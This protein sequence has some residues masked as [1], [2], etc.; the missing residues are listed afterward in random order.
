MADILASGAAFVAIVVAMYGWYQSARRPLNI[1]RIVVHQKDSE[2]NFIIVVRNVK[3][4]PVKIKAVDCYKRKRYQVQKKIGGKPEYDELFPV[5]DQLFR[6]R[7]D[8]EVSAKGHANVCVSIGPQSDIPSK[9]LFLLDT[10]HGYQELW[11]KE[12]TV[13]EIGQVE[14]YG[15]EYKHDFIYKLPAKMCYVWKRFVDLTKFF[16]RRIFRS[17]TSR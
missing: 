10:S 6:D 14:V 16:S 17:W 11:C 15:V 1:A 13:I 2:S 5:K 12:I 4:Y 3:P 9:L 8:C 7:A